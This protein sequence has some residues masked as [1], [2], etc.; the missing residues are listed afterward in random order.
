MRLAVAGDGL[1]WPIGA[2]TLLVVADAEI[3]DVRVDVNNDSGACVTR[4]EV[5]PIAVSSTMTTRCTPPCTLHVS[6]AASR[7]FRRQT[8]RGQ[9]ASVFLQSVRQYKSALL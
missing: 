9:A 2:F 3:R 7:L 6:R 5:T 1:N 8:K 4:D